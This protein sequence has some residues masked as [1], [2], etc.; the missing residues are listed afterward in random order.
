MNI[1]KEIEVTDSFYEL[2]NEVR[3]CQSYKGK[4]TYDTC[5]SRYFL[6]KMN[7][8]CGCLPYSIINATIKNEKVCG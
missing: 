3:K 6:E 7:L 2:D 8:N 5:T 4:G 1:L